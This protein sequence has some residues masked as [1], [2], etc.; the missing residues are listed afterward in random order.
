MNDI[1]KVEKALLAQG[2]E[3]RTASNG[4]HRYF[5]PSGNYVTDYPKTPSSQRRLLNTLAA[6]KRAGFLWPPP[7]R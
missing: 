3:I 5:D 2:F 1:K 4:Y 6:L 7:R